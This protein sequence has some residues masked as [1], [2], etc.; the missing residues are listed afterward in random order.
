VTL[1]TE[2]LTDWAKRS[3]VITT[4][5][6]QNRLRKHDVSLGTPG[7]LFSIACEWNLETPVAYL[8][9]DPRT[10]ALRSDKNKLIL[11]EGNCTQLEQGKFKVTVGIYNFID[12]LSIQVPA[13]ERHA[14]MEKALEWFTVSSKRQV[15][16]QVWESANM[17]VGEAA[18]YLYHDVPGLIPHSTLFEKKDN[19]YYRLVLVGERMI[20]AIDVY[21]TRS[22]SVDKLQLAAWPIIQALRSDKPGERN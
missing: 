20:V 4:E 3:L 12:P 7:D 11:K 2:K 14:R 21:G 16:R 15:D 6:Y 5:T 22:T 18:G 19:N 17:L 1:V 13:S 9:Y 10:Q 8:I